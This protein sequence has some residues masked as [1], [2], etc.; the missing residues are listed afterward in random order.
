MPYKIS[1][2]TLFSFSVKKTVQINIGIW[3]GYGTHPAIRAGQGWLHTGIEKLRFTSA[4]LSLRFTDKTEFLLENLL[5]RLVVPYSA[6]TKKYVL[7]VL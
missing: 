1:F 7:Q 4:S 2:S 5:R 6:N 3:E